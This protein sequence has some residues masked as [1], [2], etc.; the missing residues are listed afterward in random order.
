MLQLQNHLADSQ[1]WSPVELRQHQA[2]EL[3]ALAEHAR[4]T[5]LAQRPRLAA[6]GYRPGQPVD[7]E[8]WRHIAPVTRAELQEN[9]ADFRSA[10]TSPD[11]G[12]I[13]SASSSGSTGRIVVTSLH[14][15][16]Q[17][18]IRYAIGDYTEVGEP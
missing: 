9:G 14:N 10:A 15:Y 2:V 18:L 3:A 12:E 16:E 1:W 11:H 7:D 8:I 5:V 6:A 17:P 13:I 4:L